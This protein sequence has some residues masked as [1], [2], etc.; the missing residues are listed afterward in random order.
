MHSES[1][2]QWDVE[3]LAVCADGN[4]A[5]DLTKPRLHLL[6][7]WGNYFW[8]EGT[9]RY[10]KKTPRCLLWTQANQK[11]TSYFITLLSEEWPASNNGGWGV[12][13][14]GGDVSLITVSGG[15]AFSYYSPLTLYLFLRYQH[16]FA[17][18]LTSCF[19]QHWRSSECGGHQ[20][21]WD[22]R[23]CV[24]AKP[25]EESWVEMDISSGSK[26]SGV[27]LGLSAVVI[28]GLH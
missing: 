1:T 7:G 10:V 3:I 24:I 28:T 26:R 27:F 19:I 12:R 16:C 23:L 17:F 15:N 6:N 13:G 8:A 22:Q 11:A 14:G 25:E 9:V 21:P 20:K 2:T 5:C 4:T 18:I